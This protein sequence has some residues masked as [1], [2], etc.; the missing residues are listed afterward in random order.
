[1]VPPAD[2]WALGAH[3]LVLWA[4]RA[5][6]FFNT[7]ALLWLGLTVLLNA[8]RRT[9]GAWLA[10]GG[11]TLGGLFFAGHCLF[12]GRDLGTVPAEMELWWRVSWLPFVG[13]PYLWYLV[14]AWYSG[15]LGHIRER[16]WL[17]LVGALGFGGALILSSLLPSYRE[18]VTGEPVV[19]LS[20]GRVPIA[21]IAYPSYSVMCI[22]LALVALRHPNI[23]ERFMGDLAR[24]RARPWL[25][26]ASLVL[27]LASLSVGAAVAWFLRGLQ[28]GTLELLS[29]ETLAGLMLFDLVIS[30]ELAVA[31][32][33]MGRA[34]VSYEV[35]TGKTLPRRGLFR[36][37]RNS[38][39][40]AGICGTVIGG[41][42]D[43]PLAPI[44]RLVL[45]AILIA[46]LYALLSWRSYLER[47]RSME[48]LRPFVA[49]QRLYDQLLGPT[50]APDADAAGQLAALCEEVLGARVAYLAALGPLAP[51]V[52][53]PL[54]YPP[55]L[56]RPLPP[57]VLSNIQGQRSGG[58]P[59]AAAIPLAVGPAEPPDPDT[60]CVPVEPEEYGGA[61]WVVPLWSQRGQIGVFLLGEKRDGSLYTQEEMEVARAAGERL[62]DARASAELARRLMALERERLAETQVL[63]QRTRRALH[64]DV[65]PRLHTAML[66]LRSGANDEALTLL[67]EVHRD[68][69]SLLRTLPST[70]APEVARQGLIGAMRRVVEGD[71]ADDFD[72]VSWEI[73]PKAEQAAAALA[74][75]AAEV[76]FS[77][78]REAVRNAARHGRGGDPDRPLHLTVAVTWNDGLQ[79]SVVD[80]GTG[81]DGAQAAGNGSSH[82]LG[83]YSTMLA[84]VGGSLTVQ[85]GPGGPTRVILALPAEAT[86]LSGPAAGSTGGSLR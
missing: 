72:A 35:F 57:L 13:A 12:V 24:R 64:D 68:V 1:M 85:S 71:L 15:Q 81:L 48:R 74:P 59:Q 52:G 23:S 80:D 86:A 77:A 28:V 82:G 3:P 61:T 20:L 56:A 84:V 14:M 40:L 31:V 41:S 43:L 46:L 17:I 44:Y 65:L 25:L 19:F 42:L 10:G 75:L 49:S 62:L 9:P 16:V 5:L 50:S 7:I 51:L 53:P 45:A 70:L 36:D 78:A 8:E 69:A 76:L 18:L 67:S 55:E 11:L 39:I 21:G 63:D 47:E 79:I 54:A 4:V 38:L 22:V 66:T 73:E 37:W 29:Q 26:A 60:L 32:A 83:L 58:A 2:F 34:V 27:L 33:L 30:A 6:S